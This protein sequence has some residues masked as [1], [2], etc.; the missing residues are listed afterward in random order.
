[1]DTLDVATSANEAHRR[2]LFATFKLIM[3][4]LKANHQHSVDV[5]DAAAQ[6]KALST[7]AEAWESLT[8]DWEA[9]EFPASFITDLA[10]LGLKPLQED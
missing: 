10:D 8:S 4:M 9:M 7:W 6:A 3:T 1:M 2:H 5:G